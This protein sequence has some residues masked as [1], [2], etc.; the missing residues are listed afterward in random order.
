MYEIV[1][2]Y[3]EN[4]P[5]EDLNPADA[6][7]ARRLLIDGNRAFA[8]FFEPHRPDAASRHVVRVS[9][10][11]VG[12]SRTPGEA[13]PQV[14]FAAFLSCADARVPVEMI[15]GQQ[16]NDLFVVR[17]AG[18]VLG[19]EILGSLDYAVDHLGT[20]RLLG[21]LGHTGCG[22]VTA[23]V[24]AYLTPAG[25]LGIAANFPLQSII[26]SLMAPVRGAAF[27]L[28]D[29]HGE[30]VATRP[31][32]RQALIETTVILNTALSAAVLIHNFHDALGEQL[33]I[34]YGVYDLARRTVGLPEL[35]DPDGEW[36]EGLFDP[37]TDEAGFTDL[38]RRVARSRYIAGLLEV[39][40]AH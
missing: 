11:D 14:P 7:E 6:A 3:D 40:A 38:G 22:A 15:F 10:Q 19:D 37:P 33:E 9:P 16:A 2:Q 27:A 12:I 39:T 36:Q 21:V 20:V 1:W 17:V 25:Y 32:Y 23:A 24:D 26:S 4:A 18:N 5:F 13:P 34:A 30:R 8:R 29:I 28:Q 35:L 31:G